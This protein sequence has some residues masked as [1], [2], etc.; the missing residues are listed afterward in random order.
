[1]LIYGVAYALFPGP[2]TLRKLPRAH[3]L[4]WT[5]IPYRRGPEILLEGPA[6]YAR[7]PV[8]IRE[9]PSIPKPKKRK[10]EKNIPVFL[11][12]S[13]FPPQPHCDPGAH[14][15]GPFWDSLW[16]QRVVGLNDRAGSAEKRSPSRSESR[17]GGE[18][19]ETK[20]K[21]ARAGGCSKGCGLWGV[22]VG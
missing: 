20:A 3:G 16:K 13:G 18:E 22:G 4:R 6:P 5:Q 8:P 1:M 9:W 10:K 2:T 7:C 19:A 17:A 15:A 21:R 12:M 14:V 11:R